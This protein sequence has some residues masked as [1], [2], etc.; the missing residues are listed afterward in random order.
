MLAYL[1]QQLHHVQYWSQSDA[2][3][4]LSVQKWYKYKLKEQGHRNCLKRDNSKDI[5]HFSSIFVSNV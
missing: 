3:I 5:I 1:W 2:T 4:F